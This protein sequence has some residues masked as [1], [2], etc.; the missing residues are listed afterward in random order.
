MVR[1][2]RMEDELAGLASSRFLDRFGSQG[3]ATNVPALRV[4]LIVPLAIARAFQPMAKR[5]ALG[6]ATNLAPLQLTPGSG[7]QP[8]SSK[9]DFL[10]KQDRLVRPADDARAW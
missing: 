2:R 10:S 9:T 6:D 8:A 3:T 5:L 4:G 7:M 1:K